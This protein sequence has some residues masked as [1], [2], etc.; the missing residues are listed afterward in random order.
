MSGTLILSQLQ[1]ISRQVNYILKVVDEG[2]HDKLLYLRNKLERE[3]P[4]FKCLAAVDP[5]L[6]M[7]V[8]M[9]VNR[10]SGRHKD[11][12]DVKDGW[13]VTVCL[14]DHSEGDLEF[15][16]HKVR[17]RFKMGDVILLKARDLLHAVKPWKGSL[18][19]TLV[20]YTNET[21]F[22]YYGLN[23]EEIVTM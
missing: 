5:S 14:G 20:W 19:V 4:Y 2:F 18:R 23:N 9:V 1:D 13:A 22:K 15:G 11:G 7:T 10:T 12:N 16:E 6:H 8:G 17:T 21:I 3:E